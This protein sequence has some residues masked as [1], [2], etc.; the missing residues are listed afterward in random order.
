MPPVDYLCWQNMCHYLALL[1]HVSKS[2]E[3]SFEPKIRAAP[4][5]CSSSFTNTHL[6]ELNSS[7]HNQ[8]QPFPLHFYTRGMHRSFVCLKSSLPATDGVWLHEEVTS[9][10]GSSQAW[11]PRLP[12]LDDEQKGKLCPLTLL[13]VF[14]YRLLRH[15]FL[16]NWAKTP[17]WHRIGYRCG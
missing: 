4:T 15:W 5:M 9:N 7:R 10:V 13:K 3:E 14:F 8:L 17:H 12:E 2:S 1:C 11:L 6:L 16:S